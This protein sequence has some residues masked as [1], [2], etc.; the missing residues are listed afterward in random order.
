[1]VI[2]TGAAAGGAG[3]G[4]GLLANKVL[5]AGIALAVGFVTTV[6]VVAVM[7]IT[8]ASNAACQAMVE[9]QRE[10]AASAG[11]ASAGSGEGGSGH[12]E[13]FP[14]PLDG[15]LR[16][17]QANIK[18]TRSLGE[19]KETLAG[20]KGAKPDFITLNEV[21]RRSNKDIAGGGYSTWRAEPV[22]P[23]GE[24]R[25]TAVMWSS[26]WHPLDKGRIQITKS[27]S[28]L[29]NRFATW[30]TLTDVDG[31]VI[32]VVSV[33]TMTNPN[34]RSAQAQPAA[35]ALYKSGVAQLNNLIVRLSQ[36]GT[37][38]VAGDFNAQVPRR[39]GVGDPWGP[40]AQ[41]AS[42]GMASNFT[43]L[44]QF[45][46]GGWATH[47]G[48]GAIDYVFFQRAGALVPTEHYARQIN[49]DHHAVIVDFRGRKDTRLES[50]TPSKK[51]SP[52]P[53]SG[54]DPL[55]E[56]TDQAGAGGRSPGLARPPLQLAVA[57][58]EIDQTDETS[59]VEAQ[60]MK[61][62]FSGEY[63][64][65]TSEQARNA[66]AIAQVAREL[67]VPRFGLQIAIATA[68]QES[69]LVNLGS[70]DRDSLGLFQQRPSQGWGSVEEVR[71]PSL[72][73]KAF[74]GRA[75]HTANTG[76]LDIPAWQ[77]LELTAAAQA[78]QRS[79]YPDAYAQWEQI[80]EQI[81]AI[82]GGDLP[83]TG[84]PLD[85]ECLVSEEGL[86]PYTIGT[87]NV[88]GAGHTD[89]KPGG[90][91]KGKERFAGWE[92]RLPGE[93]QA[94]QDRGISVAGLQE[95]HAAQ[96]KALAST[97]AAEW[98]VWP[99]KGKSQNRVVWDP[100]TWRMTDARMVD[101]P[102][103]EGKET[104]MPLVQL[105]AVGTGQAIWVWSIHNPADEGKA[106]TYRAD[107]LSRQEPTL[108]ELKASGLP[109]FIV[110]DFNDG[111]DGAGR[112]HC[113]LTPGLSN[114]FG[115]GSSS[116][117]RP[118]KADAPADHIFGGNVQ[119]GTASVDLYTQKKNLSDHPIVYATTVG[120]GAGC[121]PTG[122]P[123]EKGLT[124]DALLV[125]RAV[126]AQFG[127]HSY[128][129]VGNRAANPDSDHPS[130][131]AVDIMVNDWASEPG[132]RHG[133]RI[134]SWIRSHARELGVT[135]V[136]WR[137]KIWSTGDESWRP[138]KHPS[139]ATDATS[140]HLDH[141]HVSVHGDK[142]VGSCAAAAGDVTYPVPGGYASTD[143]RNYGG[144]GGAWASTHTGT[145]FS[146][147]CGTP[148]L[149]A[150]AGTVKIEPGPSWYGTWL[151]KVET[152]PNTV[153]TWYAHMNAVQVSNGQKVTPGQQLGFSGNR[154]NVQGPTG[155]HLHFEVHLRNGR[156]YGS[157]QTDPS[158]WLAQNAGRKR[159]A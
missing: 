87:L 72:A 65:L 125:L 113:K 88:L 157:D 107:A 66:I 120:S 103:F 6:V 94:L 58:A 130:G 26:R 74:F 96:A 60:L 33:H 90:H 28:R 133:N 119:F 142:A 109:V 15:R 114:A 42:S 21:S 2:E 116:P 75:T 54:D 47:R 83:S 70:G 31:R 64:L 110:G 5:F 151:V 115:Q 149:A 102:Y 117:C 152:G 29:D 8:V 68:I 20:L 17:I 7:V 39:G 37:V 98:G 155:C 81:T 140:R 146:L 38:L 69:K 154:G 124:P 30:V 13:D 128:G 76:L 78:V 43:A 159:A 127:P 55:S 4:A 50:V 14:V 52:S 22:W 53:T 97:Y 148:V 141:V 144:T 145:D 93:L 67:K 106:G 24:S 41:L 138:Y 40:T 34:R 23:A 84:Q 95:V 112:A 56:D 99:K 135:Y 25:G 89:G 71:A 46:D 45:K 35:K 131:R 82:L 108:E 153:A 111:G 156:I 16:L 143:R 104:G 49:S 19:F 129:G 12:V 18:T 100:G 44:G 51:T 121:P 61:L 118:P 79:G 11:T 36:D 139:G 136:I 105:T 134:A 27:K 147:P 122:S 85:Q 62:R 57:A 77:D 9:E 101:I 91:D 158:V 10:Q 137:A 132:I 73:T 1:M 150:T 123:A 3:G 59:G 80:A 86:A 63:P 32:S 126:N 48:G 92:Q